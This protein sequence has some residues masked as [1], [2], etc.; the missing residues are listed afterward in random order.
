MI[1]KNIIHSVISLIVHINTY[2]IF[3]LVLKKYYY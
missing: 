3:R 2:L 1:D